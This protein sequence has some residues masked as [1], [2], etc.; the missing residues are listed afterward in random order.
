MKKLLLFSLLVLTM[1]SCTINEDEPDTYR[2]VVTV[3]VAP[4]DWERKTDL[5]GLNAY[6]TCTVDMP[7]ITE[8]VYAKGLVHS[9][10][11]KNGSQVSIPYV[12]HN[13]NTNDELWT[14]TID[15]EFSVGSVSF[16]V[17]HS[18]FATNDPPG[19]MSFR[20]VIMW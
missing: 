2:K 8:Y 11:V 7:E 12:L 14:T 15:S 5:N 10:F 1:V 13:E 18:D 20:V 6:Y 19:N 16:F 17:T 3:A 9:Y 4:S